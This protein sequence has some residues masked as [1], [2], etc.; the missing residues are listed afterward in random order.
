[1][2]APKIEDLEAEQLAAE[3]SVPKYKPWENIVLCIVICLT[4]FMLISGW[5][6][7]DNINRGLYSSLLVSLILMYVQRKH[8][9][10]L[11]A[12]TL[13][14]VNRASAAAIGVSVLLFLVSI[15]FQYMV[16]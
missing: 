3:A 7:F 4:I 15:Y 6:H 9:K 13:T 5:N 11:H 12:D 14:W 8:Y 16:K 1:M 2:N 10:D